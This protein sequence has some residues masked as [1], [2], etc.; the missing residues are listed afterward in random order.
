MKTPIFIVV[1]AVLALATL[2]FLGEHLSVGNASSPVVLI[3]IAL[4]IASVLFIALQQY[5]LLRHLSAQ[6]RSQ[7]TAQLMERFVHQ[8]EL[9]LDKDSLD[10]NKRSVQRCLAVDALRGNSG[11]GDPNY[12]RL[13]RLF[14]WLADEA[15][16][17]KGDTA[18][19]RLIDPLLRQYSE[20]AEQLCHIGEC[21]AERLA[22]FLHYRPRPATEEEEQ[23]S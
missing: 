16:D 2:G 8:A 21:S 1:I 23:P 18:R 13:G 6:Q 17:A 14:E 3:G 22:A 4:I 20:I 12:H 7:Q 9:L 19:R 10:P 11:R 15:N 5:A